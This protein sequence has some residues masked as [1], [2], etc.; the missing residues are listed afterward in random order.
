MRMLP[1]LSAGMGESYDRKERPVTK[2]WW[3]IFFY[4]FF[5]VVVAIVVVVVVVVVPAR[6]GPAL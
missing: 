1:V 4:Q 6:H 5:L 3:L 2:G